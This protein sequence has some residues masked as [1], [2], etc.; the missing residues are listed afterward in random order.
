MDNIQIFKKELPP[1]SVRDL[2][3][4][5]AALSTLVDEWTQCDRVSRS[6][7][8]FQEI[9]TRL[10]PNLMKAL[11]MIAKKQ[12]TSI[13]R[14]REK[15][16]LTNLGRV[17][18]Y[19]V[20]KKH[21]MQWVDVLVAGD[22][23]PLLR[24]VALS[25]E[26]MEFYLITWAGCVSISCVDTDRWDCKKKVWVWDSADSEESSKR[27]RDG[28]LPYLPLHMTKHETIDVFDWH[29]HLEFSSMTSLFQALDGV[30]EGRLHEIEKNEVLKL[31]KEAQADMNPLWSHLARDGQYD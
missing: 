22:G 23:T 7:T 9:T 4:E 16:S 20:A 17:R 24:R 30:G 25:P 14:N 6:A 21:F 29:R 11:V 8:L 18:L 12:T 1:I 5:L 31:L 2:E 3:C 19:G 26:G 15:V 10:H 28:V 27:M 13:L